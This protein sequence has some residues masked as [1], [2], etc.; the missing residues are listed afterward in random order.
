MDG[1]TSF[2]SKGQGRSHM[3]SDFLVEH[4]SGPFFSLSEAEFKRACRKYPSLI[5]P[6]DLNYAEYSATA[7]INVGQ[8]GYFDNTTILSQFERLFML[9]PYKDDF[10]G[11]TIEVVVDNARTH[12][13]RAFSVNDFGK[14]VNTRC[15]V[16]AIEY[17]DSQ[18]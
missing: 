7:G 16:D 5:S 2:F 6:N 1:Q 13:A 8:E 4:P 11:H 10:K 15:P 9:L 12:S 3:L 17:L 14:G 18:G